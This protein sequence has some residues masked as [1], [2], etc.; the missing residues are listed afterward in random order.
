MRTTDP[1]LKT[2]VSSETARMEAE[3][4][5]RCRGRKHA[6]PRGSACSWCLTVVLL[7]REQAYTAEALPLSVKGLSR[8]IYEILA[9]DA[10]AWIPLR[11]L[12]DR[13]NAEGK[14]GGPGQ[15]PAYTETN[16]S[17]RIRDLRPHRP[18]KRKV[19]KVDG[20]NVT[21]YALDLD[22]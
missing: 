19:V 16:V 12:T 18:V 21:S 14:R 11:G 1:I 10:G 17:A 8:R 6:H 9:E 2:G 7:G 20:G 15:P 3:A 13:L 5:E 4:L 22:A